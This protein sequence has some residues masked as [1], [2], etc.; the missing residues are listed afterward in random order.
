MRELTA[1]ETSQIS[2]GIVPV[3]V[4]AGAFVGGVGVASHW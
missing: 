4:V 1:E 2:G 3:L